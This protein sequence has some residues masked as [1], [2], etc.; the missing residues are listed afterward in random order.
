MLPSFLSCLLLRGLLSQVQLWYHAPDYGRSV[1]G[2]DLRHALSWDDD[3]DEYSWAGRGRGVM[4]DVARGLH[5]LHASG[6]LHRSVQP[7]SAFRASQAAQLLSMVPWDS[8]CSDH[9]MCSFRVFRCAG[10]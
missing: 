7:T 8:P 1:Q 4:L 10:T 5:F 3:A 2:G 9:L 6:V